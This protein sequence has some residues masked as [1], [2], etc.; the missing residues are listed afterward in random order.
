MTSP[1]PTVWPARPEPLPRGISGTPWEA[2]SS[3]V[4][5]TSSTLFGSTTPTGSIW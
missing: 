1:V 5:S 4:A 3:T 2:A